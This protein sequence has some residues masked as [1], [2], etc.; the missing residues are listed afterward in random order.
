M[1][2]TRSGDRGRAIPLGH[3]LALGLLQGPSELLPISSSGHLTLLPWLAQWD[4]PGV[5]A[6]LRKAFEVMLHSGAAAALVIC[7]RGELIPR[8]ARGSALV[9]LSVAPA[10]LLGY[11]FE[12]PIERRLGTPPSVAVGLIA[13]GLALALADKSPQTRGRD[14]VGASDAVWLG[15]AQASALYPGVSRGGA[16]L[17]A[18]R[19]RCFKR[20][21]AQHLSREL[22]LPVIVG[23]TVLKG[24]RLRA[25][26]VPRSVRGP[27]MVGAL[28]SFAATL[29]SRRLLWPAQD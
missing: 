14:S 25:R 2:R 11:L 12:R 29:A 6:E 19:L 16:T 8:T 9:A 23:A 22:A 4:W 24:A 1:P 26:R 3:A 21:D 15:L 28:G 13:G 17:A 27:F 7:S 10:A 20:A 18:A 5:D